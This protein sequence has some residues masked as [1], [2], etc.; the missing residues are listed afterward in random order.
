MRQL[1]KHLCTETEYL[2]AVR[3]LK[4]QFIEIRG[5]MRDLVRSG[6]AKEK[7]S[8]DP[9]FEK[10]FWSDTARGP[11]WVEGRRMTFRKGLERLYEEART[12]VGA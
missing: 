5:I 11:S 12:D 10:F 9:S 4:E 7:A 8:V 2:W 3:A 1:T 6:L